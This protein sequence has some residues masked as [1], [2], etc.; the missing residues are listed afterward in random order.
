MVP[1]I[2]VF[3]WG[4]GVRGESSHRPVIGNIENRNKKP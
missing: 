1:A 2:P 4:D 3:L